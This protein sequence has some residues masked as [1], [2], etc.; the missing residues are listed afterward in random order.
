VLPLVP[1][2]SVSKIAR[3]ARA[4]CQGAQWLSGLSNL[5]APTACPPPRRA[6]L[7]A[8]AGCTRPLPA[9][10]RLI[11]A[12]SGCKSR[13]PNRTPTGTCAAGVHHR[14]LPR[15]AFHA[16]M[17][18]LVALL[19]G[20]SPMGD[21]FRGWI[22]T[23]PAALG[24]IACRISKALSPRLRLSHPHLFAAS[25]AIPASW[26]CPLPRRRGTSTGQQAACHSRDSA[27]VRQLAHAPSAV[28]ASPLAVNG[29]LSPV[30]VQPSGIL[31]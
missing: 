4:P 9:T 1:I 30:R 6:G 10:M 8:R 13:A 2:A 19:P 21:L 15:Y 14:S 12:C 25:P 18:E 11:L 23:W 29:P 27:A 3:P 24:Q 22:V 28:A 5:L 20:Q 17:D 26:P 31:D 16:G 7:Q